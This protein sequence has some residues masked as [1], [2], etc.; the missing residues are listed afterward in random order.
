MVLISLG[1]ALVGFRW[2]GDWQVLEGGDPPLPAMEAAGPDGRACSRAG[3]FTPEAV[4]LGAAF[5]LAF[6]Y[7]GLFQTLLP[8][9]SGLLLGFDAGDIA[10]L[11]T[12]GYGADLLLLIPV[13]WLSDRKGKHRILAGG[14]ASLLLGTLLFGS[15]RGPFSMHLSSIL[16]GASLSTWMMP[17]AIVAARRGRRTRGKALGLYRFVVDIGY[18]LG[19]V[20]LGFIVEHQGYRVAG[21]VFA[22]LVGSILLLIL[23]WT[24]LTSKNPG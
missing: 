7:G 23:S 16:L 8:L 15:G 1:L 12:A 3:W 13:G 17:A 6:G 4:V 20:M 14:L 2:Q 24:T 5:L 19:P 9:R 10:L 21:M 18:I 22:G 11:M